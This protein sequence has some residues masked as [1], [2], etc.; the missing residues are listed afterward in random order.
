M[1]RSRMPHFRARARPS[2]SSS[3]EC[4]SITRTKGEDEHDFYKRGSESRRSV[5]AS[6]TADFTQQAIDK[7]TSYCYKIGLM[8]SLR[9]TSVGLL[10]CGLVMA[11]ALVLQA[12]TIAPQGSEFPVLE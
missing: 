7:E 12:Q 11:F 8:S 6:M 4:I 9:R 2:S 3:T 1:D 5:G 10:Y